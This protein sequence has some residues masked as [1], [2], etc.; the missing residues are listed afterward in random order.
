MNQS[1]T[2]SGNDHGACGRD[3]GGIAP[4][5]ASN[6]ELYKLGLQYSTGQGVPMDYVC[7]HVLFNLAAIMGNPEAKLTRKE[8]AE[9]MSSDEIALAQKAAREWM[10]TENNGGSASGGRK[11]G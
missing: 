4:H 2:P 5:G 11:A 9:L 6:D 7:A 1:H 8:I 3:L 10:N